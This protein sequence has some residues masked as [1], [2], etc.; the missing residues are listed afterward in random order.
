MGEVEARMW[1]EDICYLPTW[2]VLM[3]QIG[4]PLRGPD[5]DEGCS[6]VVTVTKR[7]FPSHR[8]Q[9]VS[10]VLNLSESDWDVGD[11]YSF[12]LIER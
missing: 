6:W 2:P 8:H 5:V 12:G 10:P 1:D 3:D 11:D 9:N 7:A 4:P